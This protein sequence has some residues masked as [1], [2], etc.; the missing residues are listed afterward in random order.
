MET[1]LPSEGGAVLSVG[2]VLVARSQFT[3]VSASS[4]RGQARTGST[5][6]EQ[7]AVYSRRTDAGINCRPRVSFLLVRVSGT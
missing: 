2:N 1:Y 6:G 5:R 7:R 4:R 3:I